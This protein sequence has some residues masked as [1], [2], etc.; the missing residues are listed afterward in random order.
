MVPSLSEE[1][2]EANKLIEEANMPLETLLARYVA[3]GHEKGGGVKEEEEGTQDEGAVQCTQNEAE[4]LVA[5]HFERG[6]PPSVLHVCHLCSKPHLMPTS[7]IGR[8][9]VAKPTFP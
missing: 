2:E 3:D 7:L 6:L 4:L 8:A 1:R 5:V 9:G